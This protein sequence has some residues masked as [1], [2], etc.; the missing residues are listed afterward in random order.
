M[1][2]P[3]SRIATQLRHVTIQKDFIDYPEGS[4]L[5]SQGNTKVLCNVTVEEGVPRWMQTQNVAGG[6]IT[7]EYSLLPRSTHT[8]TSRESNGLSGRT[9]E[10]KRLIGRSLR[11]VVNLN[12]LGPR[13]I[14]IDCDVLQADGGTRTA[15]ITGG[16]IALVIALKRLIHAG[17]IP[18]EVIQDQVAAVSVGIVDGLS[19]LDLCYIEDSHAE[20]DCNIVMNARGEFIEIQ[21][22]AEKLSFSRSRLNNLLDLASHGIEQLFE[23]QKTTLNDVPV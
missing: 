16:Y 3:D 10:I 13:T 7:A 17:K 9:H 6:W 4:V 2:R 19:L 14:T 15:S 11:S 20:V 18:N 23:L 8:R 1:I 21:G 22:T 12:L 5:Y